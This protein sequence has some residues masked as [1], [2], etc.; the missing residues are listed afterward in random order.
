MQKGQRRYIGNFSRYARPI[1]RWGWNALI[2]DID[3]LSPVIA[4]EQKTPQ[5][6]EIYR[7]VRLPRFYDFLR[8]LFAR[9]G[10]AYRL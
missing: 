4:I 1:F 8:L 5:N 7:W 6:P 10:D 3:G 9:A 2:V